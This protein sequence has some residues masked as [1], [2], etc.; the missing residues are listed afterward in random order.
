M[1]YIDS[2]IF[3]TPI[4][5]EP[6]IPEVKSCKNLL[7]DIFKGKIK[8]CTSVLT[9]DE[10]VY[11]CKR[12]F[13]LESAKKQGNLLTAFPNLV[14][15]NATLSII[16]EAQSLIEKYNLRPRDTIH[17]ATMLTKN[18]ETIISYDKDFDK[19]P[20]LTRIEPK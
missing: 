12:Q 9:W 13:G 17:G 14:F 15:Y 8:A 6:D 18:L 2:N 10:V 11:I 3:L 5:Y 16:K 1:K 7:M 19:I 20:E 4:L